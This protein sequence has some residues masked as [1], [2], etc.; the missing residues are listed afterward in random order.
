VLAVAVELADDVVAP[1]AG[2]AE[3]GL[4]RAHRAP[5]VRAVPDAGNPEPRRDPARV[6]RGSVVDEHDV[7]VDVLAE[8]ANDAL[9]VR[10]LVVGDDGHQRAHRGDGRSAADRASTLM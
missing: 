3:V 4:H 9:Q 10:G 5:G 1:L 8:I 2:V 7:V 6:V